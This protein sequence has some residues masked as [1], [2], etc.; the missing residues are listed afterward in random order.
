MGTPG[1]PGDL[2]RLIQESEAAIQRLD[3][4]QKARHDAPLWERVRS[5][6]AR[7][8]AHVTNVLLAGTVLVVALGRLGQKQEHERERQEW[9]AARSELEAAKAAAEERASS[10]LSG[11]EALVASLEAASEGRGQRNLAA[12]VQQQL[13]DWRQRVAGSGSSGPA[14]A[15]EGE[16]GVPPEAGSGGS[17]GK[18]MI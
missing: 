7:N 12:I 4:I 14:A 8:K 11:T 3:A 13:A 17:G 2:D 15:N 6:F 18:I 1:Q 10:L 5:H 9:E 16:G